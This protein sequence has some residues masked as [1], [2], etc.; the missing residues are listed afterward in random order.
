MYHYYYY[1]YYWHFQA[2]NSYKYMTD[3][4]V[5]ERENTAAKTS[6]LMLLLCESYETRGQNEEMFNIEAHVHISN[7]TEL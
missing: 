4:S 1:Y 6:R 5:C 3:Q 2:R 7:Y